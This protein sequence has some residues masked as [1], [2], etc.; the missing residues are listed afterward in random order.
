M[1]YLK[2]CDLTQEEL[3]FLLILVQPTQRLLLQKTKQKQ[4]IWKL[5]WDVDHHGN[6]QSFEALT[7][8]GQASVGSFVYKVL[9]QRFQEN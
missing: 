6:G 3:H 2:K 5:F 1:P 7:H 4:S 8:Y 9:H